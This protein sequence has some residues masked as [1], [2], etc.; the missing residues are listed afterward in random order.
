[1]DI[2]N[3][4]DRKKSSGDE[5]I[6][7]TR[8]SFYQRPAVDILE[9]ANEY[10]MYFDLPGVEKNDIDIKVEKDV[11]SLTAECSK[12]AGVDYQVLR[13]EMAYSGFKRSFELGSSVDTEKIQAEYQ[14][15]TL[16]LTLPKREEQ[17]TRHISIS[18][19]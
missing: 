19:D 11:L 1:M 10:S 7:S 17:K 12:V 5:R 18:V 8:G 2:V 3:T 15:G 16:K 4:E 13:R 9:N 6:E 14:D